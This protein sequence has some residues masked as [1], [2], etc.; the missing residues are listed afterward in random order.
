MV[1][2]DYASI[3]KFIKKVDLIQVRQSMKEWHPA[4]FARYMIQLEKIGSRP[5]WHL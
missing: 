1:I 2:S 5:K 3:M 4:L